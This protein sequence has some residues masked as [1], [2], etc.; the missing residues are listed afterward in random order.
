M[1]IEK[2]VWPEYFQKIVDGVKT[3]ELRLAD[4]ACYPDDLLVL[5]EWDPQTKEYTGRF[6]EKKVTYVGKTKSQTFWPKE[7]VEK[8]GFQIIAFK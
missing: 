6:L 5:K 1:K 7:D 2:K 8:Y 4:F 3:Y